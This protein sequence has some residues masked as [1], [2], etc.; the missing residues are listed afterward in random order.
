MNTDADDRRT[1]KRGLSLITDTSPP[2]PE[3]HQLTAIELAAPR[4]Q[5]SRAWAFAAAAVATFAAIG[6]FALFGGDNGQ[7]LT[8]GG[9]SEFARVLIDDQAWSITRH[10]ESR[11]TK[12]DGLPY[13]RAETAFVHSDGTAVELHR[14]AGSQK[15]LDALVA[16][17]S[18]SGLRLAD[19]SAMGSTVVIVLYSGSGNEHTAMWKTDGVVYEIRATIDENRLRGLLPSITTV[20]EERFLEALP[21]SVPVDRESAVKAMLADIPTPDGFNEST[22]YGGDIKD[23]YQLG[24]EVTGTV[25][26]LWIEQWVDAKA[27]G[28]SEQATEAI[29]AMATSHNWAILH[30]MTDEGAWPQV[31]WEYADAIAGDGTVIG[32]RVLTVEESVNNALGCVR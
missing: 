15:D 4:R 31:L 22:L 23:R 2:P 12:V 19:D 27:T 5:R 13:H 18:A 17:R 1:I 21:E 7:Q 26:C 25:A 8:S 14:S 28:D 29:D 6:A 16:N 9:T 30:E 11:G 3:L 24:A 10:D 20:S 32:G